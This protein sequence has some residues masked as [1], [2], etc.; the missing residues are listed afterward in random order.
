MYFGTYVDGKICVKKHA[1]ITPSYFHYLLQDGDLAS[2]LSD[3]VKQVQQLAKEKDDIQRRM[4]DEMENIKDSLDE[5]I[6]DRDE[7]KYQISEL[8]REKEKLLDRIS[9]MTPGFETAESELDKVTEQCCL[10]YVM[11]A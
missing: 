10:L 5:A 7:L 11:Y 8:L 2:H 1:H 9:A 4:L 6:N 3:T